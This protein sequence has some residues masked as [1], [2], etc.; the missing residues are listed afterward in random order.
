MFLYGLEISTISSN[1]I[2]S[3]PPLHPETKFIRYQIIMTIA[4]SVKKKKMKAKFNL[5]L[6][7]IFVRLTRV[8]AVEVRFS[9]AH[10]NL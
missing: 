5:L 2:Y 4:V 10:I 7:K 8:S 1:L 3:T 9:E 6:C